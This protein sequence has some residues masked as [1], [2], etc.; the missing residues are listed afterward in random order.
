MVI[1]LTDGKSQDDANLAA[2][3]LKN[4]GIEIFAIGKI[5]DIKTTYLPSS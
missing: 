4:M 1:L 3:T 5:T 2:Q